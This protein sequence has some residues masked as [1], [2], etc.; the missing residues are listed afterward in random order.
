M[1]D[2]VSA[3]DQKPQVE[4]DLRVAGVSQDAILQN[5][6]KMKEINK[7]LEKLRIGSCTKSIFNDLS[8]GN[9]IFSEESRRTIYEMSN[10][11]LIELRQTSA[12][13]QCPSCLKHVPEG[14]NMCQCGVWLRPNQRTM[15]RIRAAFAA[16]KTPYYRTAVPLSNGKKCGHNLWQLYHFKAMDAKRGA[17]KIREYTSIMGRWQHNENFRASQW[18]QGSIE[19]WVKYLDFISEIDIS[20]NAPYRQRQRYESTLHMRGVDSKKQGGRL[21]QLPDYRP[22]ADVL[23]SLQQNQGKGVRPVPLH[24]RTR[25]HNT[26]DP[27]VKQH[28]RIVEFQLEDVFLVI[29][30]FNMDRKRNMVE[31]FLH[32]GTINGKNGTVKSGKTKGGGTNGKNNNDRFMLGLASGDSGDRVLFRLLR[33]ST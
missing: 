12:T 4:I 19:T 24:L 27:A 28:F 22:S 16:L 13:V 10:L 15:D 8:K 5:K 26:L 17:T 23:V 33:K 20:H 25:Q 18:A 7:Q 29:F 2:S 9:T 21:C 1:L 31:L 14:L 11:E 30:I 3:V 32:L 6:E